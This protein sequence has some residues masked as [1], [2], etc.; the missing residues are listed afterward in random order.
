MS[1][2]FSKYKLIDWLLMETTNIF[3]QLFQYLQMHSKLWLKNT[4]NQNYSNLNNLGKS[5]CFWHKPVLFS[6]EWLVCE[7]RWL[8]LV[9]LRLPGHIGTEWTWDI[10]RYM[11]GYQCNWCTYNCTWQICLKFIGCVGFILCIT[12]PT[13]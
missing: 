9:T 1:F 10:L 6:G 2:S 12:R 5:V 8:W 3:C 11:L 13:C 7:S 4:T